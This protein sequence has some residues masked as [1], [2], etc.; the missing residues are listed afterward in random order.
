[1]I[2]VSIITITRNNLNDL[3]ACIQSVK[4][5]NFKDWELIIVDNAS[6]DGTAEY[7]LSRNGRYDFILNQRNEGFCKANNQAI[8][9]SKGDYILFL[10]PDVILEKNFISKLVEAMDAESKLGS[11]TGK[12]LKDSNNRIIDSTG[13]TFRKYS[14]IPVDRGEGKI[15]NGQYYEDGY[16]F[17]ASCACSMY[18][19]EALEDVK[20]GSQY[21]DEDFFT[22][23]EDVDLAWRTN[24]KGW[25]SKYVASC[26]GYHSRKGAQSK[27][28]KTKMHAFK[29]AYLT[30]I[31]NIK[32]TEFTPIKLIYNLTS[33]FK[34]VIIKPYLLVS[35][36]NLLILMP[37]MLKKRRYLLSR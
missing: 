34:N 23:F 20:L 9:L 26:I 13:I 14:F 7:L 4:D 35:L 17:G 31:K 28:L 6:V 36:L 24:S 19:K 3:K 2:K 22:Y 29:N 15:D 37:K 5:Q 30:V 1:M 11:A 32:R 27:D 8:K 33:I 16:I 12:L 25:K 18:R 21:F 10:N